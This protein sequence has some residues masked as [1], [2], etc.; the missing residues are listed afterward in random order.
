VFSN[1]EKH[2]EGTPREIGRVFEREKNE[3]SG[4]ISIYMYV[5]GSGNWI[6]VL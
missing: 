3:I 1:R 2:A 5:P 6:Y 4:K